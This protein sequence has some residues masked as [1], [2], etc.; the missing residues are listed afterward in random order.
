[1]KCNVHHCDFSLQTDRQTDIS[2]WWALHY[3]VNMVWVTKSKLHYIAQWEDLHR[4][5]THSKPLIYY[6]ETTGNVIQGLT[7]LTESLVFQISLAIIWPSIGYHFQTN[8]TI[9]TS[10]ILSEDLGHQSALQA[11]IESLTQKALPELLLRS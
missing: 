11:W 9:Q 4:P 2:Q 7:L 3:N 10:E 6:F 5:G 1:M 8:F